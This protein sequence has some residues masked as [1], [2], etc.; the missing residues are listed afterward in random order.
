MRPAEYS[1]SWYSTVSGRKSMS[2]F[3]R[4]ADRGDQQHGVAVADDDRAVGLLGQLA[5]LDGQLVV[6]DS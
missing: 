4:R 1:F 3:S 2:F 6:A 5:G